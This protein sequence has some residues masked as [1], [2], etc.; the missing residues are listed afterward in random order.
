MS[1]WRSSMLATT[2]ACMGWKSRPTSTPSPTRSLERSTPNAAG[3]SATSRG[4]LSTRYAPTRRTTIDLTSAGSN[5]AIKTL[6][7]TSTERHDSRRE[8]RWLQ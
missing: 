5:S 6:A 4:P 2:R 3:G 7:P 1:S 8:R